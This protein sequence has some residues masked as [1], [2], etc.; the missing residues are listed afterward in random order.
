MFSRPLPILP[1]LQEELK[2]KIHHHSLTKFVQALQ[3]TQE[4]V[5]KQVQEALPESSTDPVHS[6]QPGDLVWIKKFTTQGL[7]P[8]WKGPHTVVLTTPTAVKVRGIPIW[9]R[10]SCVKKKKATWKVQET[11]DPLKIRLSHVP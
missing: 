3:L 8:T 4:A 5:R 10:Q 7:T 11:Q 6:F 2:A 1:K 9:L